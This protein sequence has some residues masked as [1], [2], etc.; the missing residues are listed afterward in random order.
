MGLCFQSAAVGLTIAHHFW[1]TLWT[2]DTH[3]PSGGPQA[4][5]KLDQFPARLRGSPKALQEGERC[6]WADE[7]G[8]ITTGPPDGP[9]TFGAACIPVG[10]CRNTPIEYLRYQRFKK[11]ETSKL[12]ANWK[13]MVSPSPVFYQVDKFDTSTRY[14]ESD[15]RWGF[16]LCSWGM[17]WDFQTFFCQWN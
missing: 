14:T 12:T 1:K 6:C 7:L 5:L 9:G 3:L 15:L 17:I 13:L 2:L 10:Y 8:T 16:L 4:C 11:F